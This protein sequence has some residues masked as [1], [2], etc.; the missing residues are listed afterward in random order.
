M[1]SDVVSRTPRPAPAPPAR[2]A[3]AGPAAPRCVA[4]GELFGRATELHIEHGGSTYRLRI[5]A[6]GKLILTK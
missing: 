5:T 6:L 1:T 4:S 3:G 2:T